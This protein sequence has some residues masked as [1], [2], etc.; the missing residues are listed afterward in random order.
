MQLPRTSATRAAPRARAVGVRAAEGG[1]GERGPWDFQRFLKTVTY[2]NKPPTPQQVSFPSVDLTIPSF[3][4]T[5]DCALAHCSD[6]AWGT[7]TAR[8]NRPAFYRGYIDPV[9]QL[10][11][12]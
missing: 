6:R 1:G 3:V 4:Q 5:S 7:R 12:G 9:F 11:P 2:F 10:G 8:G